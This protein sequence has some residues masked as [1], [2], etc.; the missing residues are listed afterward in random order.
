MGDVDETTYI[1]SDVT[2]GLPVYGKDTRVM[3][4]E[5]ITLFPGFCLISK[6]IVPTN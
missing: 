5:I 3:S 2:L 6:E 1:K 4:Q